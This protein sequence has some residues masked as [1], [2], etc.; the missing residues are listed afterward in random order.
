[1]K[2]ITGPAGRTGLTAAYKEKWCQAPYISNKNVS[3]HYI[4]KCD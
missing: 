4:V 3:F 1:M 2:K